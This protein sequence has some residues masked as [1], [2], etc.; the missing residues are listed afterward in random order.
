VVDV[1]ILF[2]IWLTQSRPAEASA[3]AG[4]P[5]ALPACVDVKTEA[6]YVP[7]GY[8]HI[9]ILTSGCAKPLSCTV[10]TDVNPEPHH[11]DLPAKSRI[12]VTT[13]IGAAASSFVAKVTCR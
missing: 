5:A 8:N 13:F 4:P 2:A 9:V 6:R 7:Y 11:V 10:A 3:D 1:A 12:E